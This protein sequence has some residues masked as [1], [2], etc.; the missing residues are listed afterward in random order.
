MTQAR[1]DCVCV[2]APAKINLCLH[3]GARR[4]TGYHDLESLVV[5]ASVCDELTIEKN[6]GLFLEVAGPFGPELSSSADNLVLR[7]VRLLAE[8]A[9]CPAEARIGLVKRIPIASGVGGG[10][11]D[12]A[13]TLRGLAR[14]WQ[15]DIAPENLLG[16]AAKLGADVPMCVASVPAWVEGRGERISCLAGIPD[17][18]LVLVNPMIEISTAE[19]FARLRARTGIGG[20]R[21]PIEFT[22][23]R[24]LVEYL[25][26]TTNDL[27]RPA[28][29]IAPSIGE[30]L[31]EIGGSPGVLL[32][33]MSG[34]GATC[35]GIF[36]THEQAQ[37][38]ATALK[39]AHPA[40]WAVNAGLASPELAVP[41]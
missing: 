20:I 34:S 14:L 36:E 30:V 16:V 41:R 23:V 21:P 5:F 12:A 35:F 32:S 13:A 22:D 29:E 25:R 2:Q 6:N 10:S 39:K 9:Q 3:V 38:C 27:E 37:H 28:L 17:F 31:G 4:S 1:A 18:A 19:V 8:H 15:V 11:A 7:A 33:R 24:A 40:W 26:A